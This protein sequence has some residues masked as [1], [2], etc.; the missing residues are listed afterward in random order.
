VRDLEGATTSLDSQGRVQAADDPLVFSIAAD[1]DVTLLAEIHD[2]LNRDDEGPRI[3]LW[4]LLFAALVRALRASPRMNSIWEA[5][6][7][8][9][10]EDLSIRVGRRMEQSTD[11]PVVHGLQRGAFSE[12]RMKVDEAALRPSG[13]GS[14]HRAAIT[15]WN[16]G[17]RG[18]RYVTPRLNAG[19]AACIALGG[20]QQCFRPNESGAPA[21]RH[22][23]GVTLSVDERV[24]TQ[25][26]ALALLEA[27][28]AALANP[29]SLLFG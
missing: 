12:L 2:R 18:I 7:R 15:V 16:V 17:D 19:E 25:Q 21:R 4:H 3:E 28:A 11:R 10:L 20:V 22:E 8:I 14:E 27:L 29:L 13:D 6:R 26:D 1:L 5:G 23:I 24:V 9:A